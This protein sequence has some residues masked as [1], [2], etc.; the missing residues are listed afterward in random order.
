LRH[1]KA[2]NNSD[3]LEDAEEAATIMTKKRL[4]FDKAALGAG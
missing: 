1:L 2:I 4:F 3:L